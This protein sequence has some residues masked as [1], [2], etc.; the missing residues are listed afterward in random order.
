[1]PTV[2]MIKAVINGIPVEVEAGA[3]ILDAARKNAR[4]MVTSQLYA[5]GFEQVDVQ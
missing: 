1:M 4:A 2:T 5:L 3:S